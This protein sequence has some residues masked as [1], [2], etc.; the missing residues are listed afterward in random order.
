LFRI[1]IALSSAPYLGAS[2]TL[3]PSPGYN[4]YHGTAWEYVRNTA[5]D[6]RN[7]FLKKVTPFRQNQFGA[8]SAGQYGFPNSTAAGT[9]HF[10]ISAYQGFRYTQN[11]DSLLK[12]SHGR[13]VRRAMR[14]VSL[15]KSTTRSRLGPIPQTLVSSFV[16]RSPEIRF[17]EP[18]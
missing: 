3:S 1:R 13:A 6:A 18:Y 7:T 15:R 2:S 4:E 11:S 5:F 8:S 10:S 9:R 12:V 16:T 14:V 17:F